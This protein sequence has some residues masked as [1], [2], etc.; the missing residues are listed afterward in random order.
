MGEKCLL[1]EAIAPRLK[2]SRRPQLE[3]IVRRRNTKFGNLWILE[4]ILTAWLQ[5][6][7][8]ATSSNASYGQ[9]CVNL[10]TIRFTAHSI[11]SV[12]QSMQCGHGL[13]GDF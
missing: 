11:S 8:Q 9:I 3:S 2:Y 6:N 12:D 5:G 1:S 13:A 4:I 10:A 7:Y